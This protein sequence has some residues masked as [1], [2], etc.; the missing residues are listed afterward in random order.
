MSVRKLISRL[1]ST[2]DLK[3]EK[4]LNDD[5]GVL[6]G[7]DDPSTSSQQKACTEENAPELGRYTSKPAKGLRKASISKRRP[8]SQEYRS[9]P[10]EPKPTDYLYFGEGTSSANISR[11]LS[12]QS[13]VRTSGVSRQS[14]TSSKVPYTPGP[15]GKNASGFP[16]NGLDQHTNQMGYSSITYG[17]SLQYDFAGIQQNAGPGV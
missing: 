12:T 6:D 8:L 11:S 1:R 7:A 16:S 5:D 4:A 15:T 10:K 17:G 9:E 3:D 13:Q 14:Q 2:K